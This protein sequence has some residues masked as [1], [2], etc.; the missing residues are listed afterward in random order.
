VRLS[1]QGEGLLVLFRNQTAESSAWVKW[2]IFGQGRY[3][4]RA[5]PSGQTLPSMSADEL[6]QG[7]AISLDE[8]VNFWEVRAI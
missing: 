5:F 3:E 7:V 1:E 8:A 2:P 6:R 4:L